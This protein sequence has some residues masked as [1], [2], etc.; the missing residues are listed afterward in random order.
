MV[1]R[2]AGGRTSGSPQ[3]GL[4]PDGPTLAI[5]GGSMLAEIFHKQRYRRGAA[6]R[7]AAVLLCEEPRP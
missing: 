2:Q 4:Q 5:D 3:L 7:D 6:D 1:V